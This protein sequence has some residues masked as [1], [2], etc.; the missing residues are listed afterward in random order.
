MATSALRS[1]N[2]WQLPT[3]VSITGTRAPSTHALMRPA[4][5]R[6]TRTSTTPL[7][8]SSS[9][10]APCPPDSSRHTASRG[11][12]ASSRPSR[13]ARAIA[14]HD[15]SA[16]EPQRSTAALPDLTHSAAAS[17][18][19]LGRASYTMATTPRGTVATF[20]TERP[21]RDAAARDHPAEGVG[22]G[23]DGLDARRH[24]LDAA[25]V[26]AEP[27]E[28]GGGRAGGAGGLHVR[29]VHL[30]HG[31]CLRPQPHR[32]R[33]QR[34]VALRRPEARQRPRRLLREQR[35]VERLP[36][37]ASPQSV[38][39]APRRALRQNT[40]SSS[41]WISGVPARSGTTLPTTSSRMP[42]V[43]SA[44]PAV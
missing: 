17:A 35:L 16:E 37:G 4:P 40:T 28:H 5:P 43:S 1:T 6:G 25:G 19:T 32:H 30:E 24:R 33:A 3:P 29:G 13:R 18:V 44:S 26:E 7:R 34:A 11:S 23:G 20:S 2:T 31:G 12:P 22:L 39:G 41:R 8:P 15:P 14:R 9:S 10:T 27:V 36:H 38:H 21:P 42:R